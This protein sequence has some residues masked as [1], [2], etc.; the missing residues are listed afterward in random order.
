[1]ENEEKTVISG[2][3]GS[4]IPD[5]SPDDFLFGIHNGCASVLEY[6]GSGGVILI[7]TRTTDGI[8]VT[9]LESDAFS[10]ANGVEHIIIPDSVTWI[11]EDAISNFFAELISIQV[12][13]KNPAYQSVDGILFSRDGRKLICFPGGRTGS[14]SVPTGVEVIGKNAFR[15]CAITE[16]IIPESVT[17]IEDNAFRGSNI[18]GVAIPENIRDIG[19]YAFSCT[20][21]TTV[22]I[23]ESIVS[24]EPGLFYECKNLVRVSI[25]ASIRRIGEYAF[26]FC[27]QMESIMIPE[28]VTF[29]EQGTFNGC[30]SLARVSIPASV[31]CIAEHAFGSCMRLES[32]S[33]PE[34]V[35]VI[36]SRAFSDSGLKKVKIPASVISVSVDAFDGCS[37]M[38]DIEVAD[39]NSVYSSVDGVLFSSDRRS[40]ILYPCGRQGSYMIPAEVTHIGDHAF[41]RCLEL[42]GVIF[43]DGIQSIGY[44]AFWLCSK[45]KRPTVLDSV[46]NFCNTGLLDTNQTD[47]TIPRGVISLDTRFF[48][49]WYN[50]Q[51]INVEDGNSAYASVDGVLFTKDMQTLVR[52]PKKKEGYYRIPDGVKVIGPDAFLCCRLTGIVL[53]ESIT[54]IA[55]SAFFWCNNLSEMIVPEHVISIGN[56]SFSSCDN[57]ISINI[58]ESVEFIGKNVFAWNNP[59]LVI[60]VPRNSKFTEYF[61]RNTLKYRFQ[62]DEE[63]YPVLTDPVT[64]EYARYRFHDLNLYFNQFARRYG[65]GD[66]TSHI[67][68]RSLDHLAVWDIGDPVCHPDS[69][70]MSIVEQYEIK[71]QFEMKKPELILCLKEEIL[72][73]LQDTKAE[74]FEIT[75]WGWKNHCTE[76]TEDAFMIHASDLWYVLDLSFYD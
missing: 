43:P 29:I 41:A 31:R 57:L 74:A 72:S 20:K 56:S 55:D 25:P 64:L 34:G 65:C 18:A 50:L 48:N 60:T 28:N 15:D 42:T 59:K 22:A 24:I 36:D 39:A 52:C 45:L 46:S 67:K 44:D 62:E 35:S 26:G 37:K 14:Y 73:T 68:V 3:D 4:L 53:P 58:P 21:L 47:L 69:R 7:P 76:E 5:N 30:K 33:I 23:P 13:S 66:W 51:H 8:P 71:R 54:T 6:C 9:A 27:E 38:T 16:V 49:E 11:S 40:L 32:I 19:A 61:R 2:H 75:A 17:S 70:V 1:M 10:K 63:V 12:D